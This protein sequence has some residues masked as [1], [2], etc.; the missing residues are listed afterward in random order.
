M[1]YEQLIGVSFGLQV[2]NT[3]N[4]MG[5]NVAG[6][7]AVTHLCPPHYRTVTAFH[8]NR[9]KIQMSA[10][11]AEVSRMLR[12]E[13]TKCDAAAAAAASRCYTA[14]ATGNDY[15]VLYYGDER[16]LMYTYSACVPRKQFSNFFITNRLRTGCCVLSV[17]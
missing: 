8:M 17:I 13:V 16:S 6:L 11:S 7:E 10:L 9:L 5:L 2:I 15:R 3:L 1:H 12:S 14:C 4:E